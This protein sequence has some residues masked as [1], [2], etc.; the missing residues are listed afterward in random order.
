MYFPPT[1]GTAWAN[2]TPQSLGWCAD[3]IDT[4]Y[5]FLEANNSK[6]FIVLKNGKIV[7]EKYFGTFTQDSIWY[8]ASAGKTLTAMCV[9]IAQKEGLLK[10]TDTSS[11]FLGKGWTSLTAE[12]EDKITIWHQLT[13]TSGLDESGIKFECTDKNCLIYK[14]DA[15]TRWSY[16]NSP[17]TLLDQVIENA[18]GSNLNAFS[19]RI[20][21]PTGIKGL[22]IKSGYNNVFYSTP[23]SFARFGLL[24][25]N[26]GIWDGNTILSD[27]NYFKQMIGTSQNINKSY[28][29]LT[30]L[31]GKQSYMLPG[32]QL[33]FNGSLCTAAP[34]D[35]YAALGKNGQII[36][37][38]PSQNLVVIRMGLDFAGTN[39]PNEFNNNLWIELN[40]VMCSANSISQL[41]N[42]YPILYPNPAN[43]TLTIQDPLDANAQI[44][45]YN[46]LGKKISVPITYSNSKCE[47]NIKELRAGKYFVSIETKHSIK[48]LPFIKL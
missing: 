43:E 46:T 45:L 40:K 20:K 48:M 17:Y 16:H 31:N 37:V 32:S 24:L 1:T 7:L 36:N 23:R 34:A 10:L 6:A 22:F 35:M 3:K 19:N 30:W 21:T 27:S 29:Y 18:S 4:L 9:G 39:V 28:G 44:L 47:L 38:V 42:Q 26:K 11:K 25:L 12:K 41:K 8:W 15:G 2:S 33:V 13:M 5:K 14:A